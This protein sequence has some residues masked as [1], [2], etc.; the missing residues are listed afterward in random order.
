MITEVN[1]FDNLVK[2]L[3]ST[4]PK[5]QNLG[6]TIIIYGTGGEMRTNSFTKNWEEGLI[7]KSAFIEE[8]TGK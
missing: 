1:D 2:I 6:G 4:N 7:E 8:R 5:I 3:N